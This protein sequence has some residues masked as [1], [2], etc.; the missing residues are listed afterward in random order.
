MSITFFQNNFIVIF[1]PLLIKDKYMLNFKSRTASL[2][3]KNL[4]KGGNSPVNSWIE[5]YSIFRYGEPVGHIVPRH[6][7]PFDDKKK[8]R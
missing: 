3:L 1:E 2:N 7:P 4:K 6:L 5:E 8:T